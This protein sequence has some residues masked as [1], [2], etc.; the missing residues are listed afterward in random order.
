M[1]QNHYNLKWRHR[2]SFL[3]LSVNSQ[4][5]DIQKSVSYTNLQ[6]TVFLRKLLCLDQAFRTIDHCVTVSKNLWDIWHGDKTLSRIIFPPN[7][8]LFYQSWSFKMT[9]KRMILCLQV[10][11]VTTFLIMDGQF[12]QILLKWKDLQRASAI[13]GKFPVTKFAPIELQNS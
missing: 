13:F 3:S 10:V 8:V 7:D 2:K 1:N 6:R 5:Q 4:S 12:G 9:P 11:S